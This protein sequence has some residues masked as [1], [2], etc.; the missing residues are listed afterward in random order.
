MTARDEA[1][2]KIARALRGGKYDIATDDADAWERLAQQAAAALTPADHLALCPP[3]A[4]ALRDFI[5]EGDETGIDALLADP[6]VRKVLGDC[7][8]DCQEHCA[9]LC[10]VPFDS[11][12]A[13][14]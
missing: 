12:P 14:R 8:R 9:R 10:G 13:D 6:D 7:E 5:E 3:L 4:D 2:A 11:E 1:I